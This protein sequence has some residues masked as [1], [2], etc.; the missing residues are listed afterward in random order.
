VSPNVK[1]EVSHIEE[2]LRQYY[3]EKELRSVLKLTGDASTRKYYRVK[4]DN[5]SFIACLESEKREEESLFI[6]VHGLLQSH[7]IRV[8]NIIDYKKESGLILEE[9]LGDIALLNLL[10]RAK[11]AAEIESHYQRCIDQ[12][13]QIHQ[14]DFLQY[15]EAP[16]NQYEFDE[17]KLSSEIGLSIDNFIRFYLK[18]AITVEEE[19][20]IRS[21]YSAINSTLAECKQVLCHRDYH[22]RNIMSKDDEFVII[23]FQDARRGPAT[24]DLV[25]ILEDSYFTISPAQKTKLKQQY[26]NNFLSSSKLVDSLNDFELQYNLMACQRILKAIGSFSYIYRHKNDA[27]Y[28]KYIGSSFDNLIYFLN[29]TPSMDKTKMLL[30]KYYYDS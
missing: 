28:L 4:M 18:G 14:I 25:S 2:M 20:I 23:D 17:A 22:S 11:D 9:D 26:W 12:L 10:A 15:P 24:Y 21:E 19:E 7:S 16:I 27:R 8:P 5:Q 29:K 3:P 6:K 13:I 1:Q 30:R